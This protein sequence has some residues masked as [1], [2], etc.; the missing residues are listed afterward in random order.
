MCA[1]IKG[2]RILEGSSDNW[3]P[4][5]IDDE[6]GKSDELGF[7]HPMEP[8]DPPLLPMDSWDMRAGRT[9]MEPRDEPR[10]GVEGSE[11]D[12]RRR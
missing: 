3:S 8:W 2:E 7:E 9:S 10:E 6:G 1:I 12:D 4:P 11:P 5:R